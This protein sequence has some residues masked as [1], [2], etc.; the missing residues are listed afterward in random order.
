MAWL[1]V[2]AIVVGTIVST[3]VA[4]PRGRVNRI[5]RPRA[6]SNNVVPILCAEL[7]D[8]TGICI[9]ARPQVGDLIVVVDTHKPIAEIRVGGV[10]PYVANCEVLWTITGE[11]VRGDLTS[12]NRSQ[13]LG[14]IDPLLDRRAGRRIS[15]DKIAV[16]EPGAKVEF[17]VDRDG[18]GTADVLATTSS[19]CDSQAGAGE[20]VDV[21]TRSGR[22][23]DRFSKVWSTNVRSCV[24]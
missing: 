22:N 2:P 11:V 14:L 12:T 1:L 21:W 5:E 13:A 3:A 9:G 18:N 7:G 24:K 20:C 15:D 8:D 10:Q 16:P 19:S 17:G 4:A 6:T 23:G